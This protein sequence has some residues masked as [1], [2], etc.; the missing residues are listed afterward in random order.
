MPLK[1]LKRAIK[2][3]EKNYLN[4][5]RDSIKGIKEEAI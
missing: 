2:D 3:S 5:L 4:C 1:S